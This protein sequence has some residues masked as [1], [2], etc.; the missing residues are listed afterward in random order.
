MIRCSLKEITARRIIRGSFLEMRRVTEPRIGN[1]QRGLRSGTIFTKQQAIGA[2]VLRNNANG[3]DKTEKVERSER[4][5]RGVRHQTERRR[6]TRNNPGVG[7]V[8]NGSILSRPEGRLEHPIPVS[9]VSAAAQNILVG[10]DGDFHADPVV[11]TT[12]NSDSSSD[13][14]PSPRTQP[15][16]EIAA[17][18]SRD[19]RDVVAAMEVYMRALARMHDDPLVLSPQA[20]GPDTNQRTKP[21]TRAGAKS[22]GRAFPLTRFF[23]T[24]LLWFGYIEVAFQV[25]MG[26]LDH[27]ER[28]LR[29]ALTSN[30]ISMNTS[31]ELRLKTVENM[32]GADRED[33]SLLPKLPPEITPAMLSHYLRHPTLPQFLLVKFTLLTPTVRSTELSLMLL[34][35]ILAL[36]PLL[37]LITPRLPPTPFPF[38]IANPFRSFPLATA[39]S[40]FAKVTPPSLPALRELIAWARSLHDPE[41]EIH[42]HSFDGFAKRGVHRSPITEADLAVAERY[43]V[44]AL[45]QSGRQ[46]ETQEAWQVACEAMERVVRSGTD[47][48]AFGGHD[49]LADNK[50]NPQGYLHRHQLSSKQRNPAR[51]ST[52]TLL[53][54]T[55]PLR[56]SRSDTTPGSS[57]PSRA[58]PQFP[59]L[60]PRQSS[61]AYHLVQLF[62]ARGYPERACTLFLVPFGRWLDAAGG[63]DYAVLP[64]PSALPLF[65]LSTPSSAFAPSS[66]H[67]AAL[68]HALLN[69]TTT[70]TTGP[71]SALRLL[72]LRSRLDPSLHPREA[73]LA[74]F[75]SHPSVLLPTVPD[76]SP[77]YHAARRLIA[78]LPQPPTAALYTAILRT[79]TSDPASA[80]SAR[81]RTLLAAMR[82]ASVAPSAETAVVMIKFAIARGRANEAA[83]WIDMAVAKGWDV[84]V[85]MATRFLGVVRLKLKPDGGPVNKEQ[86]QSKD[87]AAL[88][89]TVKSLHA[90]LLSSRARVD[91]V[92]FTS[93]IQLAS[94]TPSSS[95]ASADALWTRTIL[96]DMKRAQVKPDLWSLNAA[97][98]GVARA[99]DVEGARAVITKMEKVGGPDEMSWTHLVGAHL[100]KGDIDGAIVVAKEGGV[101]GDPVVV[102]SITRAVVMQH[103][104]HKAA[105]YLTEALGRVGVERIDTMLATTACGLFAVA[106]DGGGLRSW[107]IPAMER[108]WTAQTVDKIAFANV[109]AACVAIED[110]IGVQ[111]WWNRY[112]VWL[113]KRNASRREDLDPEIPDDKTVNSVYAFM[114]ARPALV[115]ELEPIP[116][117][118]SSEAS[119]IPFPRN[120]GPADVWLSSVAWTYPSANIPDAVAWRIRMHHVGVT[121][122]DVNQAVDEFSAMVEFGQKPDQAH[123]STLLN[124]FAK[125]GRFDL[126]VTYFK[127][128]RTLGIDPDERCISAVLD[129]SSRAGD[130]DG[131]MRWVEELVNF[132]K[133][134]SQTLQGTPGSVR[135]SQLSFPILQSQYT[136]VPTNRNSIIRRSLCNLSVAS[137]AIIFDALGHVGI[138]DRAQELWRDIVAAYEIDIRSHVPA[139]AAAS[140]AECLA[141]C[142]A[143][144]EAI[145]FLGGQYEEVVGEK[146]NV[147]AWVGV[148]GLVGKG[149]RENRVSKEVVRWAWEQMEK[150]TGKD[151]ADSVREVMHPNFRVSSE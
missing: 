130:R 107:A 137:L 35:R 141:R 61:T 103:G 16:R 65:A 136:G 18:L 77:E 15:E 68:G 17:A 135:E 27:M 29:L 121:L 99:G 143:I 22:H 133:G 82:R 70:P 67:L 26:R 116:V 7:L 36:Q 123:F 3:T 124:A 134:T 106:E 86:E 49:P 104:A 11:D 117:P 33:L 105:A 47:V 125:S 32:T 146:A 53:G 59:T 38:L 50:G 95:S 23:V 30:K 71:G 78:N 83:E 5:L 48:V 132:A 25:A 28:L 74:H 62:A 10:G 138:L 96:R 110:G 66:P 120:L 89:T 101:D 150:E 122:E 126:A 102:N 94:R 119:A 145:Q 8:R 111:L 87:L 114:L 147:R 39:A 51:K 58:L 41:K 139:N 118:S 90:Y 72:L 31:G 93:L 97:L 92:Y 19:S 84:A 148:M 115:A 43:L 69:F 80:R 40:A 100:V 98:D 12:N 54:L 109:V 127:R 142:G 151:Q 85:P 129:A 76:P 6:D 14:L 131:V 20:D 21:D 9:S 113:Q 56:D 1:E 24:R 108:S 91:L 42:T 46:E 13:R 4:G 79:L 144:K 81:V 75:L 45:L 149:R 140:Y 128:M 112:W 34:R 37:D 57:A 64:R 63:G 60:P 44:Q 2:D 73:D 52:V 55:V 88:I